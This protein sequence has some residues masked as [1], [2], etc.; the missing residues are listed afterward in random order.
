MAGD[1]GFVVPQE[2]C[3]NP[4]MAERLL[5]KDYFILDMQTHHRGNMQGLNLGGC[6]M[7]G[8]AEPDYIRS[9]FMDSDTTVAVLSGLPAEIG[10]NGDL[11]GFSNAQMVNSRDKINKG[12]APGADRMLAH[13]QTNPFDGIARNGPMME[14]SKMMHDT[15]GWKCYPPVGNAQTG[16]FLTDP[17]ALA[18]IQKGID[19]KE[20]LFCVHKGFPL[21]PTWSRK[22]ADPGPD[23]PVVAKMFAEA[24]ANFVI[25][26]SA[27][28]TATKEG[29]YDDN[30][31]PNNGGCNRLF[32]AIKDNDL[33]MKNVY[34]EMGSAWFT[35]MRDPIAATHYVG[36]ALKYMGEERLVWGSECCW[37]GS[38]QC[39]IEAF[40]A[41]KMDSG[42]RDMYMYPDLTDDIKRGVF[43]LT[44][45]KLYRVDPNLCRYNL[46]RSKVAMLKQDLD[47]EV[48][49]RRWVMYNQPRIR[50]YR[51]LLSLWK[52]R[53]A[54][55]N[56]MG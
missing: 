56:I 45:A 42:L 13:C 52:E 18:F 3:M 7:S 31:N 35:V 30:P 24:G 26:H 9:I 25:Y 8:S 38:P 17:D 43:G 14:N 4:E 53:V 32:K 16:W 40:K 44:G 5:N 1:G 50:N 21:G 34:A 33:R 36:K 39:Q 28:D 2:M 10:P 46:D 41:F 12:F 6:G 20:P 22:H 23:V 55:G 47:D 51:D 54:T 19:L 29:P 15:R 37:F 48:G 27:M 49:D 11:Q